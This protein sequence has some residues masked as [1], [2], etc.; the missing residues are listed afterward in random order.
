MDLDEPRS[1]V[2]PVNASLWLNNRVGIKQS[3][4]EPHKYCLV[5]LRRGTAEPH[6][7][8]N[9]LMYELAHYMK[10]DTALA[11]GIGGFSLP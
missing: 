1:A 10:E 3:C 6:F 7:L 2:I 11:F 9:H 5:Q 4:R 8:Q